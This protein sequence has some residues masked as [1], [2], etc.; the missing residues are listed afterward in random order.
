MP[1][2]IKGCDKL[3]AIPF[4]FVDIPT[5][6]QIKLLNCMNKSLEA[7]AVKIKEEVSDIEGCD[8][9]DITI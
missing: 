7:S 8:R 6:Q 9:I 1:Q 2:R 5:L 3:N 4:S